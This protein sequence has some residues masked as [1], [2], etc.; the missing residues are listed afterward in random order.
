MKQQISRLSPHQN[1]K[2]FGIMMALVSLVILILFTLMYAVF[3][4]ATANTPSLF[5]LLLL[6]VIY[7]VLGYL[8]TVIGS[9]FYNLVYRFVG[10]IAYES[11]DVGER[12]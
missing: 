10:G 11:K 7:L 9:A 6:Q 8:A 2:V 5:M 12:V 3:T 4:P 1:G